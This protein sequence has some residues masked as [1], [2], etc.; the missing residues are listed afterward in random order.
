MAE[1]MELMNCEPAAFEA[2]RAVSA[3]RVSPS[4]KRIGTVTATPWTLRAW[5]GVEG[6]KAGIDGSLGWHRVCGNAVE[7][8]ARAEGMSR[9][10]P[11][12]SRSRRV[13]ARVRRWPLAAIEAL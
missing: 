7:P 5:R 12:E 10:A 3:L 6:S 9:G 1:P 2:Q 11:W 4:R 13:E 8:Y